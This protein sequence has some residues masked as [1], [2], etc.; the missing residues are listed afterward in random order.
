MDYLQHIEMQLVFE[1]HNE[2]VRQRHVLGYQIKRHQT[3]TAATTQRKEIRFNKEA[4]PQRTSM[5]YI[6]QQ[7]QKGLS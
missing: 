7:N 5:F 3:Q 6:N 2:N 1:F 4:E